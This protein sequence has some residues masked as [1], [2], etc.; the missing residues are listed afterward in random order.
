MEMPNGQMNAKMGSSKKGLEI[1]VISQMVNEAKGKTENS[2]RERIQSRALN[3]LNQA[4]RE[5]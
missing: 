5:G 4:D 3:E 1:G 2:Q